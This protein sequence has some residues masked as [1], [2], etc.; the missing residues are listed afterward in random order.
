MNVRRGSAQTVENGSFFD[1]EMLHGSQAGQE[2]GSATPV[3]RR[4]TGAAAAP[5][6]P[7]GT[8]TRVVDRRVSRAVA[9]MLLLV[10]LLAGVVV[11]LLIPV[12]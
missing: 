7:A 3:S 10:V 4:S 12:V 6:E 9:F 2:T 11:G 5:V 8:S 1:E